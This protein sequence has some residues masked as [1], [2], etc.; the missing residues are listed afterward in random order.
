MVDLKTHALPESNAIEL[1]TNLT[2]DV[3]TNSRKIKKNTISHNMTMKNPTG[4]HPSKH[5]E[6]LIPLMERYT[7]N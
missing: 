3:I 2:P 4:V 7:L 6:L 1:S 5:T